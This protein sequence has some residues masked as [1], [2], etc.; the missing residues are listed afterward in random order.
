[1]DR[2]DFRRYVRKMGWPL[3]SDKVDAMFNEA[4][5]D[6]DGRLDFRELSQAASGRFARRIHKNEWFSFLSTVAEMLSGTQNVF[7]LPIDPPMQVDIED[8]H[9][10]APDILT[11]R[12][13]RFGGI[14]E[15]TERSPGAVASPDSA[16]RGPRP[17]R[18]RMFVVPPK[19]SAKPNM[20][21]AIATL[22]TFAP[23]GALGGLRT[24]NLA[25]Q[26]RERSPASHSLPRHC[27]PALHS[28]VCWSPAA[29]P[30]PFYLP[31]R[32]CCWLEL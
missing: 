21:I 2:D 5:G 23:T 14:P 17:P 31:A 11:Y 1:V 10:M 20:A 24:I 6:G 7:E 28:R 27:S 13:Q 29:R 12:P 32:E 16:A 26:V 22:D 25:E 9:D 8:A 3:T 4:D 19:A 15:A 18:E 30:L